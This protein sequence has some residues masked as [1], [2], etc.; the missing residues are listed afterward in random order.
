VSDLGEFMA[1]WVGFVTVLAIVYWV[2]R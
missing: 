2:N 1:L